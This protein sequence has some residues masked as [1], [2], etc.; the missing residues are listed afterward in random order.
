MARN[1]SKQEKFSQLS[2]FY[3]SISPVP[4]FP[5]IPKFLL[6]LNSTDFRRHNTHLHSEKWLYKYYGAIHT[7]II[8]VVHFNSN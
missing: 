3:F 7:K 8:V 1:T 6:M 5:T 2:N 4:H